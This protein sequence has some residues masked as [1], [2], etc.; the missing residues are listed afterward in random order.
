MSP[1][2]TP[3]VQVKDLHR[4]YGK[5]K[6]VD[7]ISFSI[8]G[9]TV[10]G[11][12]GP[13]G[14]GKTTTMR[15]LATLDM[16][17][18][19]DVLFEGRSLMDYPDE[20]RPEIGFMPDFLETYVDITVEEYLD[21][22]ARAYRLST[23]RKKKRLADVIEFTR[24]GKLLTRPAYGL[25]KGQKQ[26]LSLGRVLI[27]DPRFLI[28][29]EPAAGLDPRAR[30]ELRTL[31][32]QLADGGKAVLFSS[33]ILAELS[34]V[35]D[36]VTIIDGGRLCASDRVSGLQ[37]QIDFGV[38]VNVVLDAPSGEEIER[39]VRALAEIPGVNR[40]EE[41][42][43]GAWFSY[44]GEPEVRSG[45]LTRLMEQGFKVTDFHTASSDLEDAFMQLTERKTSS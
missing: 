5:I 36:S 19:G 28:L 33:H 45:I 42:L 20:F 34:E 26:R 40:S 13:N 24:L 37:H 9:S 25:S 18:E 6:A 32:R 23:R 29:D 1:S 3:L 16:P 43:R 12:I 11:F 27:N 10:H 15:V 4:S 44:E 7:G 31:V 39:L 41:A 38:K 14:A 17:D 21:F 8:S 30:V 22:Y 2:D 35:C